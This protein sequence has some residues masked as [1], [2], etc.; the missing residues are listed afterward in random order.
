MELFTLIL[1]IMAAVLISSFISRFIPRISTP[2]VQI[3]LGAVMALLP[4]F[5]PMRLDPELFMVLFIAPLLYHEAHTIDKAELVKSLN[6]SLSLAIG[7]AAFTM[8]MVGV[9]LHAVWPMYPLAA[10]LALGAA[11]G[12][13]DAVAVSSIGEDADLTKRQRSIL[14]GESL[15]NDAT[16][17]IGFQFAILTAVTGSFSPSNAL[18]SFLASFI[19]GIAFGAVMGLLTNWTFETARRLGWETMTTRILLELF[20]PFLIY[21]VAQN[22][23]HIS[24]VLAVVA[25]G[26]LVRFDHTGIGPNTSKTNIVSTSVWKVLSFCLNGA[27]FVILG[28]LLPAAILTSW[29]DRKVDNLTL[30]AMIALVSLTVIVV[31]FAWVTGVLFFATDPDTGRRVPMDKRRLRSAAVMTFGGPKGTITLSLVLTIPFTL[32]SGGAFPMR[33]ELIFVA[34]G[35]IIVTL[36]L[37]NFGLPLLAPAQER[38]VERPKVEK[39]IEVLRRTVQE[40]SSRADDSNRLAVQHVITLYNQRISRLKSQIGQYNPREPQALQLQTLQWERA[41]IEDELDRIRRKEEQD[42]SDEQAADGAAQKDYQEE[43]GTERAEKY[44]RDSREQ[45]ASL[46]LERIINSLA[47]LDQGSEFKWRWHIVARRIQGLLRHLVHRLRHMTPKISENEVFLAG[48]QLQADLNHHVV[49]QLYAELGK[50]RFKTE[51]LL[52]TIINHQLIES[53]AEGK[54]EFGEVS[55]MSESVEEVKREGYAVELSVVQDMVEAG[56]ISRGQARELRRNV[57]VMQVDTDSVV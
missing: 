49:E 15:F 8:L 13:T 10:A 17:V 5:A 30:L 57:Y 16:G 36:L 40:L 1:S 28:M 42:E 38:D 25:T 33:N 4:I 22:W 29:G 21:L 11:L 55:Q 9:L 45:A 24:G 26:L 6:L 32:A 14:A 41:Y 50:G 31:R 51:D 43:T 56:E 47:H 53:S 7:L 20:L 27:V 35:V 54:T 39:S 18:G 19:G 37:A 12:P 3:V 48:R 46:I 34:A 2:L 52:T 23:L 44:T